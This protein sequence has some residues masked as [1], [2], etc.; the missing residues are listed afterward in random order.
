MIHY[1]NY[2]N[3][4]LNIDNNIINP[5]TSLGEGVSVATAQGKAKGLIKK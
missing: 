4:I 2:I 5:L 1:I 3:I